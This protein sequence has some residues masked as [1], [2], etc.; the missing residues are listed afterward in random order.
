MALQVSVNNQTYADLHWFGGKAMKNLQR[1]A[2]RYDHDSSER[3]SSQVNP[4][5]VTF[6]P[7]I[8]KGVQAA[9]AL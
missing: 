1:L 2:S 5:C 6:W 9:C 7:G 3:K 8:Y 4:E